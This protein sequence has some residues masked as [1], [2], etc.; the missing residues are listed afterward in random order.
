MSK[1]ITSNTVKPLM[2]LAKLIPLSEETAR[3]TEFQ[4]AREEARKQ[5]S[6]K[7]ATQG[8][9]GENIE[10]VDEES[11][12]FLEEQIPALAT[13]ALKQAYENALASGANVL[14][15]VDGALVETTADGSRQFLQA[16]PP[17]YQVSLGSKR[18]RQ[19]G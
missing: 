15:A 14:E 19:A 17:P 11:L 3:R 13:S 4:L 12:R 16:L 5:F 6:A 1:F 2:P 8:I 7:Q 9:F 10:H 18:V